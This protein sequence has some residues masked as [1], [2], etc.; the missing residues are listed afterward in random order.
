M[1]LTTLTT[2]DLLFLLEVAEAH[3]N[4]HLPSVASEKFGRIQRPDQERLLAQLEALCTADLTQ[5][6]VI[7]PTPFHV[8]LM[9]PD[10]R[11]G[12]R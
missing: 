12:Y 3:I 11:K 5:I 7:L 4:Q 6:Y 9:P 1:M 10:P 2:R 8:S